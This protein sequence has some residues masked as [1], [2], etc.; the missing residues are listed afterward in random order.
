MGQYAACKSFIG[1][2]SF[3]VVAIVAV[4]VSAM[5]LCLSP[6]PRGKE[7]LQNTVVK[8]CN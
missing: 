5:F 8:Q 6:R 4:F 7:K 1:R 3:T 2:C